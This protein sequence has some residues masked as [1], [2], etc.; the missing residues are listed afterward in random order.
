MNVSFFLPA[1]LTIPIPFLPSSSG[2]QGHGVSLPF[3]LKNCLQLLQHS[4]EVC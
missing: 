2:S 4:L 3:G 1:R